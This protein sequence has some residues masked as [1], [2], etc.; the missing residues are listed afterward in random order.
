MTER[1]TTL[2]A[3]KDWLDITT[4]GSDTMLVRIIDAASQ[5]VLGWL[6][7]DS[8]QAREYTQN[9][10]GNG[11]TSMLL[12]NWPVLSVTSVGVGGQS[13]P[14]ASAPVNGL[15]GS[16]YLI[17]DPRNAPQSL[18]LFGY[19]YYQGAPSQIVYTAGFRT[20]QSTIIPEVADGATYAVITPNSDGCWSADLGVSIDGVDAPLSD[21]GTP[22]PGQYAVD[23]WG[24]YSFNAADVGKTAIM[25]YDYTPWAVSFAVTELIGE[26][27][28]RKDRIG[29]LSKTLGGQETVTFSQKDMNDS[30]RGSLQLYNNVVPM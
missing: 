11:K 2:A 15:P 22:D 10:R 28:K 14:A 25:S 7:R 30:I 13:I 6:N 20:S 16:G 9:F 19:G 26:W 17:S 21:T 1:L 18:E 23:E 12:R 5:F 27:Y 29:V 4:D 3:V 24:T 8:F